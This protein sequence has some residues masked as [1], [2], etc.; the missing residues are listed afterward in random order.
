MK[1]VHELS[2]NELEEL[3]Y[4]YKVVLNIGLNIGVTENTN[5]LQNTF[6]KL[7]ENDFLVRNVKIVDGHW[8]QADGTRVDERTLVVEATCPSLGRLCKRNVEY[9]ATQ[10]C[11]DSIAVRE[12]LED[13]EMDE[14]LAYNMNK[15][16]FESEYFT[17]FN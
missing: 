14:Y 15:Q 17:D 5:Q 3:R 2:Q 13:G 6:R 12:Y 8:L 7:A 1:S 9:I 11:Q 10:L 4:N 16:E